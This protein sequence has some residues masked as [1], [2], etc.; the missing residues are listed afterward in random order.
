MLILGHMSTGRRLLFFF[1]GRLTVT[2]SEIG[3]LPKRWGVN[4]KGFG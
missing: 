4:I 3:D 1:A 2:Y